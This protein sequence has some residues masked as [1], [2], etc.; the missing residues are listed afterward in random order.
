MERRVDS[1]GDIG[2]SAYGS[3]DGGMDL[4]RKRKKGCVPEGCSLKEASRRNC[5]VEKSGWR[6]WSEDGPVR[7]ELRICGDT[8]GQLAG[9]RAIGWRAVQACGSIWLGGSRIVVKFRIGHD[10][11]A[12]GGKGA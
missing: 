11:E 2:L 10:G 4:E 5:Y 6:W 8:G 12:D 9:R 1:W 3:H 7:E